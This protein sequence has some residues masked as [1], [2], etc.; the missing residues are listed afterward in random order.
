M[1]MNQLVEGKGCTYKKP[2]AKTAIKPYFWRL[3][4]RSLFSAGMGSR[5]IIASVRMFRVAL[6][7]H[8]PS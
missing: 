5:K 6:E 4:S 7:N 3:G 2:S 1:S 8:T